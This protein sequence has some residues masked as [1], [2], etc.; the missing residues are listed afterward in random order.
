MPHRGSRWDKVLKWAEFFALQISGYA[1]ALESFVPDS[2]TAAKLIWVASQTLLEVSP[3][4]YL[5]W[6]YP[7]STNTVAYS[8]KLG[9]ENGKALETTF[10]AFYQLGLS[11]SVLLRHNTLL[12]AS[13]NIRVEVGQSFNGML[14][15]VRDVTL[16]YHAKTDHML[17]EEIS[18]DFNS[19]FRGQI[20]SF[21]VRKNHIIN[22]MWKYQLGEKQAM[23]IVKLR[24]WLGPHDPSLKKLHEN[25]ALTPDQRDEY[26][27]EW[28]QRR[29]LDFSRSKDDV[30]ALFGPEGCGKTYL[31]RWTIERLQRP[32]GKKT[33]KFSL[34]T[35]V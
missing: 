34:Y 10:G 27:C 3:H 32:L 31:S 6:P 24:S 14:T 16:Y 12:Y 15:I 26:T 9:P 20:E 13:N 28:F 22:G 25:R 33:R 35:F 5:P 11:L 8:R 4:P 21:N 2:H 1:K 29:L 17:S 18:L 30:L 7:S 19:L 23:D